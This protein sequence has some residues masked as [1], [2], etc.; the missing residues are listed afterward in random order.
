MTEE[1]MEQIRQH[2]LRLRSELQELEETFKE[3]NKPLELDQARVG[4]LSRMDAMQAQQM[5]LEASR[6]RQSHLL[7]VEGALRRIESG[8]YG[9]CF[10]CGEEIGI[11]RLSVDPANTRCMECAEK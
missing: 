3:T 4:R 6:R 2:L 5:A 7:K 8:E 9:Y 10:V 1:E 11:R